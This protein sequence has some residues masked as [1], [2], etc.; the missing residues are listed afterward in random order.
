MFSRKSYHAFVRT[1]SWYTPSALVQGLLD[2]KKKAEE[3]ATFCLKMETSSRL[4]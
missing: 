2:K 1:F 4:F 3:D